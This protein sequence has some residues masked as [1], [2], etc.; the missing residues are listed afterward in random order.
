MSLRLPTTPAPGPLETFA[1]SFDDLFSKRSQREAF[2]RYLEGLLLPQERNKT[3]TALAN[4]EPVV[5]STKPEAQRLQGFLSESSWDPQQINERR[6]RLLFETPHTAPTAQGVLA[7]DETGDRKWGTKTAHVGRQYL[8]SIG[9]IDSG[10]VSVHTLWADESIYY[11]IEFEPY[12]PAHHFEKGKSDPAFRTKPQIAGEL[13]VQACQLGVPFRAVVADSLYGEHHGFRERL[14]QLEVGYVLALKPSHTWWHCKG[15][16]GSVEEVARSAVWQ[17]ERPGAWVAITRSFRDGHDERWWA[18]EGRCACYDPERAERLVVVTTD[19]ETLPE[20][21]TWYVVT[22][23]PAPRTTRAE[24]SSLA[25]A[26]LAEVV[27]L[28]GLRIW[29]EQ[30][31]KQI[32]GALGWA[33][34]QVRADLAMRRH[35]ELVCCAQSF[36]WWSLSHAPGL[37]SELL[38]DPARQPGVV[39]ETL[40]AQ[41]ASRAGGEKMHLPENTRELAGGPAPGAGL[42]GALSHAAALLERMVRSAPASASAGV[43]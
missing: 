30:S 35:W 42:P 41:E 25:A 40:P 31:Y 6:L 1:G 23:L 5:G 34:Y 22:N 16:I 10:V 2:R 20:L 33:D 17:P 37:V 28:Y 15:E 19:P 9:K 24:T 4:T 3:L 13:V 38:I 21:T 11:P 7:I 27:R 12:T 18:L 8:G 32:K 39:G 36:C 43:A 26:D 29:I 14:A